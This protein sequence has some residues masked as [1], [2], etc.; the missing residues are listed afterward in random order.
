[1]QENGAS[2]LQGERS[3]QQDVNCISD[4][5]WNKDD[6]LCIT[7]IYL[8]FVLNLVNKQSLRVDVLTTLDSVQCRCVCL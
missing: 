3:V 8:Y 7:L 4:G 2:R 5:Y 1:M 6:C